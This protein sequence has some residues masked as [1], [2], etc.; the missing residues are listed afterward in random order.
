[1][2]SGTVRPDRRA[3]KLVAPNSPSDTAKAM[4]APAT[5]V[6]RARGTSMVRNVRQR[7][8]PSVAA[9]SRRRGSIDASVGATARTTNGIPT[10]AWASGIITAEPR[11]STGGPAKAT[12]RPSPM[13]TA[14]VPRGSINPTSATRAARERP[15]PARRRS[16]DR[17]TAAQPPTTTATSVAQ[18]EMVNEVRKAESGRTARVVPAPLDD[19]VRYQSVEYPCPP[20]VSE[21]PI[22]R[23]IG[24]A[25]SASV[26]PTTATT[27]HRSPRRLALGTRLAPIAAAGGRRR[28][29]RAHSCRT[30]TTARS[31]TSPSAHAAPRSTCCTARR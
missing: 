9:A 18:S 4:P 13:V 19:S 8:L 5:S 17:A 24:R 10:S 16:D 6:R 20:T 15:S 27:K 25:S 7:E 3:R 31:C 28:S 1:M 21:R 26:R 29:A 30:A 23:P 2:T 12:N 11:R 22:S 14:D